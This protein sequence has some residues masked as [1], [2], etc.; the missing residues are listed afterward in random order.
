[1]YG[2]FY[3]T[4]YTTDPFPPLPPNAPPSAR[5]CEARVNTTRFGD[6]SKVAAGAPA[7][8]RAG[9]DKEGSTS[10]SGVNVVEAMR[11]AS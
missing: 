8:S 1:M 4:C 6:R 10:L 9:A 5:T 11:Q 3:P 2:S 7:A